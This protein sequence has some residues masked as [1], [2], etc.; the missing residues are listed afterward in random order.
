MLF[1]GKTTIQNPRRPKLFI[2][3]F[4][5]LAMVLLVLL[6]PI[7]G[8]LVTRAL[9]ENKEMQ[10][11]QAAKF[12]EFAWLTWRD[13]KPRLDNF[14]ADVRNREARAY[15]IVYAAGRCS[16]PGEAINL[17]NNAKA[18]LVDRKHM[19]DA[20]V[21]VVNGG[22]RRKR[23]FELWTVPSGASHPRSTPTVSRARARIRTSCH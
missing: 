11:P 7:N 8:T 22:F 5:Q 6:L 13:L 12:D 2:K 14:S 23:V 15:I 4:L 10:Q 18:Y 20:Q 19:S 21:T 3:H 16:R 1:F 9:P 17:A